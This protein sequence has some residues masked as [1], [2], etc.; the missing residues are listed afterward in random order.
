MWTRLLAEQ[1]AAFLVLKLPLHRSSRTV[2][3]I[4]TSRS[5]QR[6]C[7][8]KS[9]TE[10]AELE[11]DNPDS[12]DVTCPGIVTRCA[13]LLISAFSPATYLYSTLHCRY[14]ERTGA[15]RELSLADYVAL[16]N[17]KSDSANQK[18]DPDADFA[19]DDFLPEDDDVAQGQSASQPPLMTK[20][21]HT[22]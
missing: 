2:T 3:F 9:M 1:E 17:W 11:K 7:L 16:Y 15:A 14:G 5:D 22:T 4:P 13:L 20:R 8:L 12:R 19:E 21:L 6:V 18:D 10:L